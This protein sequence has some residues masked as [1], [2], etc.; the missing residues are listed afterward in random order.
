MAKKKNKV[1]PPKNYAI[2]FLISLSAIFLTYY[3]FSWH[4]IL[5]EKRYN[6]SYLISSN[7]ISLEVNDIAEIKNTFTEAPT[8]Y[9]IYIGY[10]NDENVYKLEKNIKKVIDKYNLNDNFYYID[11][12]DLKKQD[13]YLE[14]LNNALE[15]TDNKITNIPTIL[16]FKDGVLTKDGIISR[17]DGNIMDVGDFEHL[18]EI[19]EFKK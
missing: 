5:E 19:Y 8:E 1:I 2:V 17:E 3:I 14:E 16:F 18:L 11:V 10:R 9:F 6:E 12:T 7:T 15:L 13:N 4:S